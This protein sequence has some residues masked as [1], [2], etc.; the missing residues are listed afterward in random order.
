MCIDLKELIDDKNET[1]YIFLGFFKW[2]HRLKAL[3]APIVGPTQITLQTRK[4]SEQDRGQL[5]TLLRVLQP[6]KK[7]KDYKTC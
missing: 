6:K 3:M 2:A 5:Y 4:Y 7:K 1:K